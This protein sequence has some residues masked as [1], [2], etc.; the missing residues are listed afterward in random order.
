MGTR[1]HRGVGFPSRDALR[2]RDT[3]RLRRASGTPIIAG[4]AEPGGGLRRR[5]SPPSAL[6]R[7]PRV[8][9]SARTA[10]RRCGPSSRGSIATRPRRPGGVRAVRLTPA[11][12]CGA[13]ARRCR[14]E[15]QATPHSADCGGTAAARMCG[16]RAGIAVQVPRIRRAG[17][18]SLPAPHW[19]FE[20]PEHD[21]RG[22]DARVPAVRHRV[23]LPGIESP[24]A[25]PH[26]AHRDS[27]RP[28]T[29]AGD[30]GLA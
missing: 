26:P 5:P 15:R 23:V 6:S 11:R 9:R 3:R 19:G 27:R 16:Y 21:T 2:R 30:D 29:A 4:V 14:R 7:Q 17:Q 28:T 18:F 20:T 12:R 24:C 25:S 1:F 13:S 10:D 22:T 8:D